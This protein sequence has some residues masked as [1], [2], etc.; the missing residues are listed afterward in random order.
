MSSIL[1]RCVSFGEPVFLLACLVIVI[2][3][4]LTGQDDEED[5]EEEEAAARGYRGLSEGEA[6]HLIVW[7]V[8]GSKSPITTITRY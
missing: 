3:A 7:Q 4:G 5:Q 8:H 2:M 6:S 1:F